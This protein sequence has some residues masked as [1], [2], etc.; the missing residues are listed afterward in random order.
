M[1]ETTVHY[2]YR[3]MKGAVL[4]TQK[5]FRSRLSSNMCSRFFHAN[6]KII[7]AKPQRFWKPLRFFRS[8]TS[9]VLETSEV[10]QP[11]GNL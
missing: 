5:M 9:E 1:N 2:F 3:D 7:G 11:F 10:F 6:I 8:Q 4:S